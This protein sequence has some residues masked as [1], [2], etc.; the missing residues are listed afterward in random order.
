[1]LA[2]SNSLLI[3]LK[4]NGENLPSVINRKCHSVKWLVKSNLLI[5]SLKLSSSVPSYLYDFII[6]H[7]KFYC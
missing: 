7:L 4:V 1:M 6:E 2:L 5:P 3:F